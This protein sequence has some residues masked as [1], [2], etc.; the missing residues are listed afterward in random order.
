MK[1]GDF[2]IVNQFIDFTKHREITFFK[3]FKD[4]IQHTSMANPFSSFL[5][6]KIIQSCEELNLECH[7]IGTIITIEGPRFSTRAESFMF[8]RL[9]GHVINMSTAPEAILANEAGLEYAVIAMIT[10]YDCWKKTEAPVTWEII[11]NRMKEN[12]EKVKHLLIKT[13]ENLSKPEIKKEIILEMP[14]Q[15]DDFDF[16]KSKIRTIPNFPKQ[17]IMFRDI[18]TL[19]QDREGFDKT[20]KVLVNRYKDKGIDIIAGIESRGFIIGSILASRLGV[21]FVP[22][23]KPGKL[24]SE[25]IKQE[26]ELEYGT[27]AV[28]IHKDA[29][30][31][32]ER[33]LLVDDLLATGGTA[34]AS[35]KLIEFLGGKI[36]ECAF[37][38]ELPELKGREKLEETGKRVFSIIEFEGE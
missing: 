24:P 17:G 5:R 15:V 21:G 18:T 28:E 33:V 11:E 8:K 36:V 31:L 19:L 22:I 16:I 14:K 27:D 35:C 38:I 23:R 1:P 9:G 4:G 34:L 10:D 29:I 3:T 6:D 37:V 30:Q 32:G 7:K 20:I 13:I 26:Y 12:S 2:V 25:T